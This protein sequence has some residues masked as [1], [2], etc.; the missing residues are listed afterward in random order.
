MTK[1]QFA[2]IFTLM[3]LIVCVGVLASKLNK[4]GFNDPGDLGAVLQQ[5]VKPQ[6]TKRYDF[7]AIFSGSGLFPMAKQRKTPFIFPN[8]YDFAF[9]HGPGF[10]HA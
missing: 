10:V 4:D 8:I 6:R 3:A 7:S 9:R 2:I 5:N 1:R